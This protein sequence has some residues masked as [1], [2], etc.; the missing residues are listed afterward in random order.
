A[1]VEPS[2]QDSIAAERQGEVLLDGDN[3]GADEQRQ[4]AEKDQRMH[5]AGLAVAHHALL[6]EDLREGFDQP[7]RDLGDPRVGPAPAPAG[8][9]AQHA[10]GHDRQGGQRHEVERGPAEGF[11]DIPVDLADGYHDSS[12]WATEARDALSRG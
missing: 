9:I 2:D 1:L 5:R 11:A 8:D 3:V 10:P 6:A 7:R 12:L 4:E